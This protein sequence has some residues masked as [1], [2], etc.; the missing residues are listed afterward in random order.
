MAMI[1][2]KMCGGDLNLTQGQSV[3]ECEYC[4]SRQT[5]PNQDNEKKLIQF[6]RAERLRRNCEF[7]K[8][9]GLYEAIVSEFRQE[10]EA[11]WGLVLCRYGIE[12]VD[13]P[14]TGKK[15]PTCHR[16]SF[17]SILED[18]DFEQALEN[19]DTVA[20]R[21]YRQEAKTIDEIRRGILEV[22]A[23]EKPYDIFI[24][25]KETD[26]NGDRTLDSVLA[27]DLYDAL[28][29][30]GYRV[31]FARIT[32]ED[33]LGQA[34]E[35]YIFAA[36]N[37]ARVMLAVGTDYE[38]FNAV[39]VKNEWSRFL[40]LMVKDK[41]KY[42]I[43]CYKGID[44][45]DMPKEFA[46]LQ[47]QDL[48]KM[49]AVQ[50]LLRN[51]EKYIPL[52]KSAVQTALNEQV[53]VG[54]TAGNKIAAALHRGNMALEDGE[55]AKADSFFED[56]LSNDSMNAQAYLGKTLAA[57]KCRTLD[58][59]IRKR[60]DASRVVRGKKLVLKPDKTHVEEMAEQYAVPGYLDAENI[61]SLYET[62][63]SYHSDV[64][65]RKQQLKDEEAFWAAHKNLTKAEKFAEG[66]VAETI[67]REK[68][69]LFDE[70]ARRVKQAEKEETA[71]IEA[72]KDRWADFREKM[73]EKVR[74]FHEEAGANREKEYTQALA[75]AKNS[76]DPEELD[77]CAKTF[78]FLDD[79][80]DSK[81]LAA[82]CRKR[83]EEIREEIR[84]KEIAEKARLAEE[85]ERRIIAQRKAEREAAARKKKITLIS[86]AAV[87]AVIAA[88]VLVV[89]VIVPSSN[90]NKADKL[91][92]E[93]N[94]LKAAA[95]FEAMDGYKDSAARSL[96]CHYA[97]GEK[98]FAEG[99]YEGAAAAFGALGEYQDAPLKKDYAAAEALAAEGK[100]LEAAA[101]FNALSSYGDAQSRWS[102]C[103]DTCYGS[104]EALLAEK[105]YREASEAF[106]ALGGYEDARRRSQDSLYVMAED[107]AEQKL[108]LEA[109]DV[110]REIRGFEDALDRMKICCYTQGE[111]SLA[112]G[113]Y[114]AA[115]IAFGRA[116]DYQDA[117]ERSLELWA[118]VADRKTLEASAAHTVG[119]KADGTVVAVGEKDDGRLA[120]TPWKN[121]I[122]I[123]AG[124]AHT[125]ALRSDGTVVAS[126]LNKDGQCN[127]TKWKD[128]V[129]IAANRE[130]TL[131]LKL[132]GTVVAVGDNFYGNCDVGEWTDIVAITAGYYHAVGLKSD[133]TVI[134]AGGTSDNDPACDVGEWKNII[135]IAAGDGYT[136]GLKADGTVVAVG[137]NSNNPMAASAWTDI[138][139]IAAGDEHALGLKADGT[140]VAVGNI[141]NGKC[142]VEQWE[143]IVAIS[144]GLRHSV[145]LQADGTAVS[146]QIRNAFLD[147]GQ[148]NMRN[149]TEMMLP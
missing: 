148:C 126:G 95:V 86:C 74:L 29:G 22:S 106:A 139:A 41:D 14:G 30:K 132:D 111:V 92:A 8:A 143:N 80:R 49:G 72:V 70:L 34:Y 15:I 125:V 71:A 118:T 136:L 147:K 146:T 31:F 37:S 42:L 110:F 6:E 85:E 75:A 57:E 50:D 89:T 2:C 47:A 105:K 140:V 55:W 112:A 113:N 91:A 44:A 65:E 149:F 69:R 144:A 129:A 142:S 46:R 51:M 7:D 134:A 114:G 87:A 3:A 115:A 20:R 5:V 39:W 137:D 96:Q 90:Y 4:G 81:A 119:V 58:A 130:Y 13:D 124:S 73:D 54:G 23:S 138:V 104:A 108:Y 103:M 77:R 26:E 38:Y 76:S 84:Q 107:L 52:A 9:A 17:D 24:C 127:V 67:A 88:I 102:A 121:N 79:F 56:V 109:A 64:S 93:G 1:K 120:V 99:D 19:A 35:P 10:A 16:V 45:Y 21:V 66:A 83:A 61:R 68:K 100:Y 78:T 36:L 40:K 98:L 28:T 131:G 33:K 53:V 32:L 128:I 82:H 101:A 135:A 94:F 60:L 145:G 97:Q 27:Q 48:G 62:D 133:G 123:A 59:F 25:Y 116:G 63:L 12:Y 11:Y 43:P 117:R 141:A 122:A 18:P